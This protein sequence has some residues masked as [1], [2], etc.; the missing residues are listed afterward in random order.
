M[1][2]LRALP[3]SFLVG[4]SLNAGSDS[5]WCEALRMKKSIVRVCKAWWKVGSELLYEEISMRRIGQIPALL[6]TLDANNSIGD[7]IKNL[8]ISCFIPAGYLSL[9][10]VDLARIFA[11]CFRIT[12]LSFTAHTSTSAAENPLSCIAFPP[13]LHDACAK[14]TC[15]EC[16]HPMDP[17]YLM[18]ALRV[19]VNL[20]SLWI[21]LPCMDGLDGCNVIGRRP[22][23][24]EHLQTLRLMIQ[25]ENASDLSMITLHWRMPTLHNVIIH[26]LSCLDD[27]VDWKYKQDFF[28]AFGACLRYVH[29]RPHWPPHF[30]DAQ[31]SI[32]HCPVLEHLAIWPSPNLFQMSLSHQ[33][34]KWIDLWTSTEGEEQTYTALRESLSQEALPSL[35]GLREL[36]GALSS[37]TDWPSVLPP[38]SEVD[39]DGVEYRFAGVH[40]K[41]TARGIF[42]MDTIYYG[43]DENE[44]QISDSGSCDECSESVSESDS[45]RFSSDTDESEQSDLGETVDDVEHDMALTIFAQTLD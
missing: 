37:Q 24:L 20:Q 1:I 27:T 4:S 23:C 13:S 11:L 44:S 45:S 32:K 15:L 9:F 35:I 3:P 28:A 26:E 2:F 41:H 5:P 6:R 42:K 43:E 29:I 33:T 36:D 30:I 19:C 7:M 12:R 38:D 14:L 10:Q 34:V 39:V 31:N 40:V 18:S 16:N 21:C 25:S 17:E 8:E 22:L